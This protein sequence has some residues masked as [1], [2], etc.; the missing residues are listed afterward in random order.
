MF[1]WRLYA[2]IDWTAFQAA[3][4]AEQIDVALFE[5]LIVANTPIENIRKSLDGTQAI[6]RVNKSNVEGLNHLR[7]RAAELGIAY[8]EYEHSEK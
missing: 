8:T 3:L 5:S 6:V 1:E 2:I 4:D 7:A